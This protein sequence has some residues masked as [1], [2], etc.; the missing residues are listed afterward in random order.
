MRRGRFLR[1]A[2]SAPLDAVEEEETKVRPVAPESKVD[3]PGKEATTNC[4]NKIEQDS[5]IKDNN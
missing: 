1:D 4:P 5:N 2:N 3:R